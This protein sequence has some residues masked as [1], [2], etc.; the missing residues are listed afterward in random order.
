LR[1]PSTRLELVRD[2]SAVRNYTVKKISGEFEW[3]ITASFTKSMLAL[4]FFISDAFDIG[5]KHTDAFNV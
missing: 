3:A 1:S 5:A 2:Q 4:G